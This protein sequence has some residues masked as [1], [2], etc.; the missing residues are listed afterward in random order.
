MPSVV[1]SSPLRSYDSPFQI[2]YVTGEKHTIEGDNIS[3]NGRCAKRPAGSNHLAYAGS[4]FF[5]KIIVFILLPDIN[6]LFPESRTIIFT[7]YF[8]PYEVK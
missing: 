8:P 3:A 1:L 5:R 6:F 4:H 7:L 2:W